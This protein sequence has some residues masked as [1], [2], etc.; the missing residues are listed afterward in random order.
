MRNIL[1]L[2]LLVIGSLGCKKCADCKRTYTYN[3]KE[4]DLDA[5][6]IQEFDSYDPRNIVDEQEVCGTSEIKGFEKQTIEFQY[7]TLPT[8]TVITKRIG[9]CN[10]VT[11]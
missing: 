5:N 6:L 8:S 2:L 9:T 3:T 7:D 10:C 11:K 1:L 4:Y